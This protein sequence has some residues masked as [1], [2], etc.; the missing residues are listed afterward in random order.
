MIQYEQL[1]D[2]LGNSV[3]P[4]FVAR[5][6]APAGPAADGRERCGSFRSV[7]L[8]ATLRTSTGSWPGCRVIPPTGSGWC[9]PESALARQ[10]ALTS[11]SCPVPGSMITSPASRPPGRTS[12]STERDVTAW[13]G[14]ARWH[15]LARPGCASPAQVAAAG[16][17]RPGPAAC[18]GL[19]RWPARGAG[20][21]AA[22]DGR[23]S[24]HRG[25]LGQPGWCRRQLTPGSF[26]AGGRAPGR[27]IGPVARSGSPASG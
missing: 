13:L 15:R 22:R 27:P 7:R 9:A 10:T 19:V 2:A 6:M 4:S 1:F 23:R 25:E 18:A 8:R 3:E 5:M 14:T 24:R 17:G 11:V 21:R 20:N 12:S 16:C 26:G